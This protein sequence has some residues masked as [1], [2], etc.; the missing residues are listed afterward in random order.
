[1][2][3]VEITKEIIRKRAIAKAIKILRRDLDLVTNYSGMDDSAKSQVI[4]NMIREIKRLESEL[5]I[6]AQFSLAIRKV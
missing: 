2:G 1:M 4:L 6:K 5:N 3:L